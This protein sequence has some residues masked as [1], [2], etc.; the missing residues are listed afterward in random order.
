MDLNLHFSATVK[1]PFSLEH[2]K[3]LVKFIYSAS[4]VEHKN[5]K[6]ESIKLS[7]YELPSS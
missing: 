7:Y 4:V 5:I 3:S 1:Y 6:T 2:R